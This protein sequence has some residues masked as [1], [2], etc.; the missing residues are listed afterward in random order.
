MQQKT[1]KN[2]SEG[3]KYARIRRNLTQ[4]ALANELQ[5]GES[6][7]ANWE[8]ATNGPHRSKL[9]K[10]NEFFGV[11]IDPFSGRWEPAAASAPLVLE[12]RADQPM[13]DVEFAALAHRL[14]IECLKRRHF[15]AA[16]ALMDLLDELGGG[17]NH[18]HE[19]TPADKEVAAEMKQKL[20]GSGG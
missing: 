20:K 13:G 2:F 3:L 17:G 1:S 16:R 4:A 19:L 6:T 11:E 18:P 12:D 8:L 9:A 5:E 14:S 10:L 7:I 15:L